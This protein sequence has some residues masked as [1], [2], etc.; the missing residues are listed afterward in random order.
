M[1]KTFH[2][3]NATLNLNFETQH[4]WLLHFLLFYYMHE[5][6][7]NIGLDLVIYLFI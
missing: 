7:Q 1:P 6:T 4:N 3:G 5:K 2:Q